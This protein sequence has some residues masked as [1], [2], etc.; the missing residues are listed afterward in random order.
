MTI[1]WSGFPASVVAGS[2]DVL[3]G[4]AGG[5]TNA[6]FNASSFLFK[7]NNLSDV[8]AVTAFGNISPLT[9]NGDTLYYNSGANHRL[10]VGSSAQIYG[11]SAGLPAWIANPGLLIANNL[12]DVAS[13]STTLTNLGLAPASNVTFASLT[14][15]G[16]NKTSSANGLTAFSGGGQGSALQL[17][18]S[19]NRVTTVAASNDSVKLPVSTAGSKCTVINSAASN[20]MNVFPQSGDQIN[21]LGANV[22]FAMIANKAADFYCAVAGQWNAVLSA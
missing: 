2:T 20:S 21:A 1:A 8:T 6:R 15:T 14:T 5:T 3:V 19:I 18:A 17:A 9:T 13:L 10:A 22:A 4:L 16:V 12:S 7:A 11:I